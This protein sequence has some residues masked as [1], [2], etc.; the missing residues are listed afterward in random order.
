[1]DSSHQNSNTPNRHYAIT[2]IDQVAAGTFG[3]QVRLQRHGVKH[4]KF[5]A[6]RTYGSPENALIEAQYW[7]DAL[8][9]ELT[10][11]QRARV[12]EASPRNRS[13]V[14]GV[15]KIS[16][17]SGNGTVYQFWQ[18]TWSPSPGQRRCVKFSIKRHGEKMA[19]KLAVEARSEGIKSRN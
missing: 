12:C 11:K 14:V 4:G 7:R 2:R 3:W 16:V 13:G 17:I 19:F 5:F 8:L 1:M 18:A 10:N 15:S 6:D 9:K